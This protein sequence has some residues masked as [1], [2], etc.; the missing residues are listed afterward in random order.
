LP[1]LSVSTTNP[2][3]GSV[4]LMSPRCESYLP[5]LT[6]FLISPLPQSL[7]SIHPNETT[8]NNFQ[9]PIDWEDWWSWA[10]ATAE[11]DPWQSLLSY[12]LVRC[13]CRVHINN[14]NNNIF[15]PKSKS[16]SDIPLSLRIM[17]DDIRSLQLV[18]EQGSPVVPFC[19]ARSKPS[20]SCCKCGT[21][22]SGMS[23][24]K[25]HE[26]SIMSTYITELLCSSEKLGHV[27]YVVD[28]GAGQVSCHHY[29]YLFNPCYV[30]STGLS[31]A[32]SPG[33]WFTCARPRFISCS[34]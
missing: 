22:S 32:R 8:R 25:S 1:F 2:S 5:R 28:V 19:A 11:S 14:N 12:Y 27:K 7:L 10:Q 20:P 34:S 29:R 18:R 17:I 9:I 31:V 16:P 4:L 30:L 3:L 33:I 23:P 24:K 26:V 6:E 13:S 15:L 21:P